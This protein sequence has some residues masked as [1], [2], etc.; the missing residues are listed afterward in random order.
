MAPRCPK[1][2]AECSTAVRRTAAGARFTFARMDRRAALAE[3]P[4]AHAV[5]LRLR[6]AGAEDGVIAVALGIAIEAVGPLIDLAEAK[7]RRLLGDG[8]GPEYADPGPPVQ[9][10]IQ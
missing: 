10:K 1:G 8:T 5:A 2:R 9:G 4:H 7:L 3:L 6:A